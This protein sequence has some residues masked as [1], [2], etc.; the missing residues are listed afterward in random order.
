VGGLGGAAIGNS[1]TGYH[2]HYYHPYRHYHR[3]YE[4][5]GYR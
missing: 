3:Y 5:P 4:G 2:R 1:M